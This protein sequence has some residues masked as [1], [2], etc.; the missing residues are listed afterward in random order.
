VEDTGQM[1]LAAEELIPEAANMQAGYLLAYYFGWCLT[2]DNG[3]SA[4]AE[5][6]AGSN[7]AFIPL[8]WGMVNTLAAAY[9]ENF[10]IPYAEECAASAQ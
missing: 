2:G 10:A 7:A 6:A 8:T 4:R 5:G 9:A 1:T 3:E